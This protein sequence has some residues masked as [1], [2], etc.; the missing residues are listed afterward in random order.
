[1]GRSFTYGEIHPAK[2]RACSNRAPPHS[3]FSARAWVFALTAPQRGIRNGDPIMESQKPE[4]QVACKPYES[5]NP[6][7]DGSSPESR[8]S[9]T[10][11]AACAVMLLR[12]LAEGTFVPAHFRETSHVSGAEV[13]R[14]QRS[15][16]LVLSV[17]RHK[18]THTPA[19]RNIRYRETC[20]EKQ[21]PP[22]SVSRLSAAR[23]LRRDPA[24]RP[25]GRRQGSR[26]LQAV[27]AH[28]RARRDRRRARRRRSRQR[29]ARR[30]RCGCRGGLAWVRWRVPRA[31]N[32]SASPRLAPGACAVYQNKQRASE[33]TRVVHVPN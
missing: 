14:L 23:G 30:R 3:R 17:S 21:I 29:R 7:G 18:P 11:R 15:H 9:C 1:M 16:V 24:R 28:P 25:E 8:S 12:C 32:V 27:G 19:P 26:G 6:V 2:I 22:K 10:K 31:H 33:N 13:V 4:F 5:L 20:G